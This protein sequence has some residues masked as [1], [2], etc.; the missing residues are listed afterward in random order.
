MLLLWRA[1]IISI[2]SKRRRGWPTTTGCDAA[3]AAAAAAI[4]YLAVPGGRPF[5]CPIST[6]A[7]A[8]PLLSVV[9][10]SRWRS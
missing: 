4:P 10:A 1:W 3:A 6:T 9:V 5:P 7:L 2:R 8:L